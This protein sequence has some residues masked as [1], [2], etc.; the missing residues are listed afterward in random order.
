LICLVRRF[1]RLISLSLP[2]IKMKIIDFFNWE[3]KIEWK[4]ESSARDLFSIH[5]QLNT[6]NK[7]W[8][9]DKKHQSLIQLLLS[10]W[11]SFF[12]IS[13]SDCD[14]SKFEIN[15]FILL[16]KSFLMTLTLSILLFLSSRLDRIYFCCCCCFFFFFFFF[17]SSYFFLFYSQSMG[18]T[19]LYVDKFYENI[20]I[21]CRHVSSTCQFWFVRK[22]KT[23][24][25]KK[26]AFSIDRSSTNR[27]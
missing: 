4:K 6:P 27:K 24:L 22:T 3:I 2:F 14:R 9:R 12:D 16:L 15:I 13:I 1:Y 7:R 26:I 5:C 20:Y 23:K 8:I 21:L 17:F 18:L 19:K 11:N 10:V 25:N